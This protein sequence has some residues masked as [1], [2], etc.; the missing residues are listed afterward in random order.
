LT[1][2]IPPTDSIPLTKGGC[3]KHWFEHLEGSAKVLEA[4]ERG[5]PA[6]MGSNSLRYLAGWPDDATFTRI[7]RDLCVEVGLQTHDLPDG[8]RMREDG[9]H[10]FLFNYAPEPLSWNGTEIPPAGVHWEDL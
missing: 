3:F 9:K 5:H 10:R 7:L 8:L 6:I 2:S 4:T 1:E